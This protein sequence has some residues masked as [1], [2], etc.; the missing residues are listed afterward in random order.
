M[1]KL[2]SLLLCC[3]SLSA[4]AYNLQVTNNS[5]LEITITAAGAT[6]CTIPASSSSTTCTLNAY[7]AYQA[8]Y[9]G[10]WAPQGLFTI[11]KYDYQVLQTT[12]VIANQALAEFIIDVN[13]DNKYTGSVDTFETSSKATSETGTCKADTGN[14]V[15]C[16]LSDSD[17]LANLTLTLNSSYNP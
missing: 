16:Q 13:A 17:D 15:T 4:F 12:P 2:L 6:V 10:Q 11:Q 5:K 1:K 3:S 14:S 8:T 7:T 9:P